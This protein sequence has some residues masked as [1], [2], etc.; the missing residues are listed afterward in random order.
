[1]IVV[2]GAVLL[3]SVG[4]STITGLMS[5]QLEEVV[6]TPL[7]FALVDAGLSVLVLAT[8]FGASFRI[9]PDGDVAWRDVAVGAVVTAILF[10]LGKLV[11]TLYL[12]HASVIGAYGVAGSLVFFLVWIYYSAAI[13]FLGAEF[14]QLW[15]QR[16]GRPIEPNEGAVRVERTL[17]HPD[18]FADP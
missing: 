3:V 14:T 10:V 13:F 17:R 16:Q 4:L 8:L 2:T 5:D 11:V 6:G 9:L 7:L 18:D 15:A 1:M 12:T